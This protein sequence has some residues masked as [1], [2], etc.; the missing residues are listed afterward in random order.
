VDKYLNLGGNSSVEAYEIVEHSISVKF[1]KTNDTY[2]YSYASTGKDD[3]ERMKILA[4]QGEG[5]NSY[6][7]KHAKNTYEKP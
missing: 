3:V 4:K 7:M 1:F 6:I 2:I 5:L